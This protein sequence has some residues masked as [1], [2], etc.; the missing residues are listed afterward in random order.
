M[1]RMTTRWLGAAL[2]LAFVAPAF[3]QYNQG[4]NQRGGRGGF[5]RGG[6]GGG[7]SRW[8]GASVDDL[9]KELNLTEDQRAKIDGIVKEVSD[10]IRA[11]FEQ[12]RNNGGGGGGFQDMRAEMEKTTT[13]AQAK[14]KGV[15]TPE[16]QEKYTKLVTDRRAQSDARRE[17]DRK[18]S[19]ERHVTRAMEALKIANAQEAEAVKSLVARVV[20]LQG[21]I[22]TLDRTSRDK[23]GEILKSDGISDEAVEGRLKGLRAERKALEDQLLQTQAELGKVV[24]AK[25]EAELFR[26]EI[27]R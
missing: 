25:Q 16:Q 17:E 26:Q 14:V 22:S 2:A 5:N 6:G 24:S 21:D 11:R 13:D 19:N 4:G 18:A 27:L 23:V 20:K 7:S 3:A 15:M 9:Q 10:S 8:L 1:F 12:A